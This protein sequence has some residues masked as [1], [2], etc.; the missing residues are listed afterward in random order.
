MARLLDAGVSLRD[1]KAIRTLFPLDQ[2]SE[3]AMRTFYVIGRRVFVSYNEA[4]V[5]ARPLGQHVEPTILEIRPVV[6]DV[7]ESIRQLNVRN[8]EQIGKIERDRSILSGAPMIAGTRIPTSTIAWFH[9]NGYSVA[10]I[11]AEFP[12]LT[13]ADINAAIVFE[14]ESRDEAR[15]DLLVA[16]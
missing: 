15:R 4:I 9:H 3:W 11:I 6:D 10:E 14:Q 13:R 1:L 8:E 2:A 12:R 7:T 16:S 5:A